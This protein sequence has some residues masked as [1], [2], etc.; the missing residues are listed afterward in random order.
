MNADPGAFI[1]A[2]RAQELG[3]INRAV[4]KDNLAAATTDLAETVAAKLASAVKIGKQ[5]FYAQLEMPLHKAYAYTGD[6]MVENMLK[7][8]TIEGIDAFLDKRPPDWSQ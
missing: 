8:D 4:P 3:L 6:V 7:R 2:E 1:T 5:A